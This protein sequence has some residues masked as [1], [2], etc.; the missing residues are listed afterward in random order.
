MLYSCPVPQA[1]L[2]KLGTLKCFLPCPLF[3][4]LGGLW[5]TLCAL[6]PEAPPLVLRK[7][8]PGGEKGKA[9]HVWACLDPILSN[10]RWVFLPAPGT[11]AHESLYPGSSGEPPASSFLSSSA[12]GWSSLPGP[13]SL[14]PVPLVSSSSH[15]RPTCHSFPGAGSRCCSE[16][17]GSR[18]GLASEPGQL[19]PSPS[20]L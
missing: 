6:G 8:A 11:E 20:L 12:T 14:P 9:L 3:L 4:P 2:P 1:W 5:A 16:V 19:L 13:P 15:P 7:V 10:I 18:L 17:L